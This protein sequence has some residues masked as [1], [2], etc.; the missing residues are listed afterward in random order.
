MLVARRRRWERPDRSRRSLPAAMATAITAARGDLSR[1]HL[2]RYCRYCRRRRNRGLASTQE[3]VKGATH[4]KLGGD[5]GETAR[6]WVVG[7]GQQG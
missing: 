7:E 2:S 6:K 3:T 5:A 1:E 4:L